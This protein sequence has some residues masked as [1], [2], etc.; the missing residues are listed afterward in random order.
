ME[1]LIKRNQKKQISGGKSSKG[2]KKL[3]PTTFN[4]KEFNKIVKSDSY[5][6]DDIQNLFEKEGFNPKSN[7]LY[8]NEKK[9]F[10]F[11][12]LSDV[13]DL[14][15]TIKGKN[16]TERKKLIAQRLFQT[17]LYHNPEDLTKVYNF[18][19][20]RTGV[21]WRQKDLGVGFETLQ[22]SISTVTGRSI[23]AIREDF[24]KI[25][26][27]GKILEKSKK[28]QNTLTSLM[29]KKKENSKQNLTFKYV[30]TCITNLA[31]ITGAK[32]KSLKQDQIVRLIRSLS[33]TEGKYVIRFLEK[34]LKI[35]AAEK[36]FQTS[37]SRAFCKFFQK[38]KNPVFPQEVKS[39]I[40]EFNKKTLG[41]DLYR[42]SNE[43]YSYLS[44][45]E[46]FLI[47]ELLFQ[48]I[49][50]QY[51]HHENF[52][53]AIL[54]YRN[55]PQILGKVKLTPETPCKPMLAKPT[56]SLAQIFKR[57]EGCSFTC[58]YKYDGL[59]G[60]IHFNK[61]KNILKIFSRNLEDITAIYP[62]IAK[63]I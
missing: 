57:L 38:E 39:E 41:K 10:P 59:R 27:L 54:K 50:T 13:F 34:N 55:I 1:N 51:P 43:F 60:Q 58:E 7:F 9:R 49:I 46:K 5:K 33:P 35:G 63:A 28:G 12:V 44:Q 37:L 45:K 24:K 48:K 4:Q 3:K 8:R 16:S 40:Y 15:S 23:S 53:K 19:C 22:R 14:L 11:F 25:G 29:V 26:D 56:K 62:D 21:E 52:F 20:L 30:L 31:E 32:S 42:I 2:S 47:W 61:E 18:C 36:L 17:L 6:V